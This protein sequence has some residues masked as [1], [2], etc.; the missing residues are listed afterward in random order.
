MIKNDENNRNELIIRFKKLNNTNEEFL[1]RIIDAELNY[2]SPDTFIYEI[3]QELGSKKRLYF[4]SFFFFNYY[5]IGSALIYKLFKLS[6]FSLISLLVFL[7]YPNFYYLKKRIRQ[8]DVKV[9]E[10]ILSY[11]I[12]KL[13]VIKDKKESKSFVEEYLKFYS[14]GKLI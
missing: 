7:I 4:N 11:S 8:I 6:V 13:G 10:N 1:K 2:D 9:H 5:I 12:E 3:N 14:S